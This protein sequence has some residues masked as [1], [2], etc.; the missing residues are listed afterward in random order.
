MKR[1]P[2]S[3]QGLQLHETTDYMASYDLLGSVCPA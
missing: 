3:L 1:Q 2:P